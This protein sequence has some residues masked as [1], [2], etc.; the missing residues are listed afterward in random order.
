MF[1]IRARGPSLTAMFGPHFIFIM[2]VAAYYVI[3]LHGEVT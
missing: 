2:F 1:T 3:L